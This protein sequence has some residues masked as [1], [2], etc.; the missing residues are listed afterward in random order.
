MPTRKKKNGLS[1]SV[2]SSPGATETTDADVAVQAVSLAAKN[3]DLV[4]GWILGIY[5]VDGN[6]VQA[7]LFARVDKLEVAAVKN[8]HWIRTGAI[9][10][11]L[12]ALHSFFGISIQSIA[13]FVRSLVGVAGAFPGV[14]L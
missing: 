11:G 3:A 7:G 12:I 8:Y 4:K 13:E 9:L 6:L 10:A 5:D 1:P 14:A 2:E